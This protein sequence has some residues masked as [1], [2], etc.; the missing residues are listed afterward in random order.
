MQ[1]LCVVL[2]HARCWLRALCGAAWVAGVF[3][4]AGCWCHLLASSTPHFDFCYKSWNQLLLLL[5]SGVGIFL[6]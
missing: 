5:G 2:C 4:S 3:S 1:M 6:P